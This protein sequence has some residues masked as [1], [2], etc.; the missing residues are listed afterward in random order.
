MVFAYLVSYLLISTSFEPPGVP[1]HAVAFGK[2]G[3]SLLD[4]GLDVVSVI[5]APKAT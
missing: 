3:G 2:A 5:T 4:V 1:N